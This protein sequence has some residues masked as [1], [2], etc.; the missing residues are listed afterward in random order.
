MWTIECYLD[1]WSRLS[2][3]GINFEEPTLLTV[4]AFV[5]AS[6]YLREVNPAHCEEEWAK[7]FCMKI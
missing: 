5:H 6:I 3:R 4:R 2:M 1:G 7:A